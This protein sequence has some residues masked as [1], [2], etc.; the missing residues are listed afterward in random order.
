MI[1]TSEKTE[2]GVDTT[3]AN[4]VIASLNEQIE[5]TEAKITD[6]VVRTD[7]QLKESFDRALGAMRASYIVISG[8]SQAMGGSMFAAFSALYGVAV[9]GISTYQSIAAAMA[10]VPGGQVQAILMTMSLITALISLGGILTGQEDFA[11]QI[12]GLNMAIQGIGGL[13]DSMPFG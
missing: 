9:A 2:L 11:R 8:I 7:E 10:A 13:L 3:E 1:I 4:R 6:L 5:G 12:S